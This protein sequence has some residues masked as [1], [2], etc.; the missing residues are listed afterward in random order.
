MFE[1]SDGAVRVIL[2]LEDRYPA[3]K[4]RLGVVAGFY[5]ALRERLRN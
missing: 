3:G 4:Y 2:A 1:N 5:D